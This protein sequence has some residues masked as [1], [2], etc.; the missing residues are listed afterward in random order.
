MFNSK[1]SKKRFQK[2]FTL[3][4]ILIVLAI[5]GMVAL[6]FTRMFLFGVRGSHDNSE[7][8]LAYNLAREKIEEIRGLP[9]EMIKSDYENFRSVYQDRPDYDE[10]YYDE[11]S[12]E[13]YFSDVF[14][15]KS[16]S[17]SEN[18]TTFL[19]LKPLYPKV[20]LKNIQTYPEDYRFFRRVV[21]VEKLVESAMPSNLKEITVIVYNR[22]NRKIARLKTLAGQHQ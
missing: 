16:L 14:S 18:K 6:P 22:N 4:E 3:I 8:V 1:N 12:F 17:D 11:E 9:Y 7:Y 5:V 19:R 13:K 10:A 20:Y 15:K 2:G 21:K